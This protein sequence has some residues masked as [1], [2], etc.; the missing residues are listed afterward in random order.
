LTVDIG[1]LAGSPL[2]AELAEPEL[3]AI[4]RSGRPRTFAPGEELCRTGEACDYCWLITGGLVDVLGPSGE[5]DA[6]VV[7]GRL[8]KG[9]M[10][11]E[12]A[13]ILGEPYS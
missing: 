13:V 6:G 3:E 9:S 7:V 12:V 10:V 2:F 8:R 5:S 1:L 4:I 11:G